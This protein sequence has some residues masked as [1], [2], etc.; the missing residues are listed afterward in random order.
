MND[1]KDMPAGARFNFPGNITI[2]GP[3]FDIHDNAHVEN[4]YHFDGQ[5]SISSSE[6][7]TQQR[8][9]KALTQLFD[10]GAVTEGKQW[11]AIYRVLAD[12]E[13]FP[14][15]K[16]EF[17]RAIENLQLGNLNPPCIYDNWRKV[18]STRLKTNVDLWASY[19]PTACD[20]DHKQIVVATRLIEI[21]VSSRG[22]AP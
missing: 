21:L 5:S 18:I 8:V 6:Q 10:E 1:E 22:Q 3:M 17:C 19:L 14:S 11:Y 9:R 12:K 4:H 20:T 13:G 7:P 16:P 2:N 15:S